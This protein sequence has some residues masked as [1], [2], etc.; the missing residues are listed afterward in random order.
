[1]KLPNPVAPVLRQSSGW[2][3]QTAA[4][5]GTVHAAGLK[6]P[7]CACPGCGETRCPSGT[8]CACNAMQECECQ[9]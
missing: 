2:V 9:P 1:M 8:R 6:D 5:E 3:G 7:I 4:A